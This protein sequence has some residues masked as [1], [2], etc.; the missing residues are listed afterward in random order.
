MYFP[1]YIPK[2]IHLFLTTEG[3]ETLLSYN[4]DQQYTLLYSKP[5]S[6]TS[7]SGSLQPFGIHSHENWFQLLRSLLSNFPAFRLNM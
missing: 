5:T 2:P 1:T 3:P 4:V 7:I 6:L